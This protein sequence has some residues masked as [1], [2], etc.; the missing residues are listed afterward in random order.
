MT[1]NSTNS[2]NNTNKTPAKKDCGCGRR[3]NKIKSG[4]QMVTRNGKTFWQKVT[5]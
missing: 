4:M 5:K 1:E 2:T 3:A